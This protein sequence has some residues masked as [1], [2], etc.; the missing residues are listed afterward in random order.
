MTPLGSSTSQ[1]SI[2]F[3]QVKPLAIKDVVVKAKKPKLPS[4]MDVRSE[5]VSSKK[6]AKISEM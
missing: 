2:D 4:K 1:H 5:E 3:K 6:E